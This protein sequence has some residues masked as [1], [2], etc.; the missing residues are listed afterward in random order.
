MRGFGS[1]VRISKKGKEIGESFFGKVS[2]QIGSLTSL[3]C[4]LSP[5]RGHDLERFL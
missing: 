3:T 1:T 5:R 2:E 4:F